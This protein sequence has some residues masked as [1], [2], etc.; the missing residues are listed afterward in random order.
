MRGAPAGGC[1]DPRTAVTTSFMSSGTFT[2]PVRPAILADRVMIETLQLDA[3][4]RAELGDRAR[5][6]HAARARI[7]ADYAQ[8]M[9]LRKGFRLGNIRRGCP[10]AF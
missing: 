9:R 7:G 6:H 3:E 2:G 5:Q 1:P 8:A 10:K 4:G